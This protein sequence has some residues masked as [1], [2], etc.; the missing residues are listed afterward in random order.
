LRAFRAASAATRQRDRDPA[1]TFAY[2]LAIALRR[3]RVPLRAVWRLI[4]INADLCD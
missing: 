4:H 1:A 3:R 2:L